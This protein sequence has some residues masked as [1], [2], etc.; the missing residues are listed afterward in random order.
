[1]QSNFDLRNDLRNYVEAGTDAAAGA[2]IGVC[3]AE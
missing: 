3:I 1:M 2:E